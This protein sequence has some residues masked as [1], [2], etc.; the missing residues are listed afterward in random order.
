[1]NTKFIELPEG[2]KQR[3][4]IL[5]AVNAPI[6]TLTVSDICAACSISRQTFYKYFDSKYDISY[7]YVY[8]CD[9]VTLTE[10][11]RSL[12]W[13]DG[14]LGFFTLLRREQTFFSFSVENGLPDHNLQPANIH[15]Q[16]ILTETLRDYRHI[17]ITAELTFYI[18]TFA[19]LFDRSIQSWFSSGM[20]LTP[21]E[22]AAY[23]TNCVPKPL[24]EALS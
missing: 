8:Y 1:M 17:Q 4:R 11:G 24:Y 3:M 2:Y 15:R 21:E 7:W 22:F 16:D 6:K 5:H 12:T 18:R 20:K 14:V 13:H 19:D 23:I 10:I 9:S